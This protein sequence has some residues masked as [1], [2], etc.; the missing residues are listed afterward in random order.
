MD[1]PAR[2][3]LEFLGLHLDFLVSGTL[4]FSGMRKPPAHTDSG[5]EM[6]YLI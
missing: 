4:R 2:G 3:S 5:T 1:I 6:L